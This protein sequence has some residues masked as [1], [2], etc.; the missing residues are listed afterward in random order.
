MTLCNRRYSLP[1]DARHTRYLR[2]LHS[3]CRLTLVHR[4]L[5]RSRSVPALQANRYSLQ[6]ER[7]DYTL[8]P[9][10]EQRVS[11]PEI[12]S[13][14]PLVPSFTYNSEIPARALL[15]SGR[16][17]ILRPNFRRRMSHSDDGLSS[18]PDSS[19]RPPSSLS[20]WAARYAPEGQRLR[21]HSDSSS[22]SD[23]DS[24]G[25]GKR[26]QPVHDLPIKTVYEQELAPVGTALQEA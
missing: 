1:G 11:N 25:A 26:L 2:C 19:S 4:A 9:P 10:T 18:S 23:L 15:R 21:R 17:S 5:T 12:F 20:D 14:S 8:R 3:F 22:N 13:P 6:A 16:I 24:E 7:D